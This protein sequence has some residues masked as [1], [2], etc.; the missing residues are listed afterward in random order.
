M[1]KQ[2]TLK[3][4]VNK[5]ELTNSLTKIVDIVKQNL[6]KNENWIAYSIK[7]NTLNIYTDTFKVHKAIRNTLKEYISEVNF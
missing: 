6:S 7:G 1:L 4:N 3:D 2:Y 5:E